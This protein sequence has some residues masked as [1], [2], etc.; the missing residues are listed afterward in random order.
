MQPLSPQAQA[1][2]ARYP[3]HEATRDRQAIIQFFID[4]Q[5]PIFEPLIDFQSQFSG[6][7]LFAGL[8]PIHYR[9]IQGE[10]GYPFSN[11]T[12]FVEFDEVREPDHQY[13]FAVATSQYPMYFEIDEFGRYY[14]DHICVAECFSAWI[15]QWVSKKPARRRTSDGL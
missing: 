8:E 4:H 5:I 7:T 12:A 10:G 13:L 1:F 14:E 6:Y 9:L 3:R 11:R 2:L 15:E